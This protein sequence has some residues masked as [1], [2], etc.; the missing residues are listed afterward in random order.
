LTELFFPVIRFQHSLTGKLMFVL[1][2]SHINPSCGGGC[3]DGG[4]RGSIFNVVNN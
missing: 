3:F 4:P 2:G 1:A